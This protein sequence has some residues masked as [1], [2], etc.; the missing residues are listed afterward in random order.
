MIEIV[1][2]YQDLWGVVDGSEPKLLLNQASYAAWMK[3]A[4][5]ARALIITSLQMSQ[6]EHIRKLESPQEIW[7]KLKEVHEPQDRQH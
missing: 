4:S 2:V 5:K 7:E 1:L 6:V 3:K